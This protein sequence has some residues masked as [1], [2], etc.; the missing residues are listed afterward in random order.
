MKAI[1]KHT[2]LGRGWFN[3]YG[4]YQKSA[5]SDVANQIDF[6]LVRRAKR[7]YKKLKT[8][9]KNSRYWLNGIKERQSNLF[10]HWDMATRPAIRLFY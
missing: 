5:M 6:A 8:S 7:K 4:K 10:A 3:Y 2:I 1:K 9:Y